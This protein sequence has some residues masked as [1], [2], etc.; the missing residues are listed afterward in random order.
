MCL[1][2]QADAQVLGLL[3]MIQ[4]ILVHEGRDPTHPCHVVS[5]VRR[6]QTIEV[7]FASPLSNSVIAGL[8]LSVIG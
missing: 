3:L 4:D 5:T 8:M 7:G 6:P 2:L 1:G